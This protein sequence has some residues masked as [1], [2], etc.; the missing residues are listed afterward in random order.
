[1]APN[2]ISPPQLDGAVRQ[3]EVHLQE[4][5]RIRSSHALIYFLIE[6]IL[7]DRGYLMKSSSIMIDSFDSQALYDNP[8]RDPHIRPLAIYLPPDYEAE[9]E[10]YPTAYLLAGYASSG[11]TFLN[12]FPWEEDIQ[13]RLDRLIRSGQCKPMIVVMPDCFTR[14]GGSQY[15]DSIAIG[16]YQ[17]YLL[18]IVDYIDEN[19][20]SIPQREFRAILGKS[21]GGYG[22]TMM[23][24]H[25]PE[26]FGLVVDHSGDKFFEKCYAKDLLELPDLLQRLDVKTILSN[27]YEVYPKGSD[28]FQLMSIAAMAASYSPNPDTE[29]SFDWPIDIHTGELLPEI[30]QKWIAKDPVELLSYHVDALKSLNLLFLDCG[31]RDEYYMHLGCRLM[32]KRLQQLQIPHMYEE[33]DGGHRHT[34]FRYDRSFS[35]ISETFPT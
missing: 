12:Y 4:E 19:Y 5:A 25:H 24:M 29:L 7:L 2:K 3:T 8:L 14:F 35:L 23:A 18:E 30:W 28:F 33:F 9:H 10:R 22:A 20:R 1:L 27:P 34:N 21:S 31:N 16:S 6:R 26:K 32:E 15:L 11:L 17:S 13:S